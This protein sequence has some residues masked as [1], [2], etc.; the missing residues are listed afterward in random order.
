MGHNITAIVI[1][2]AFARDVASALDLVAVPLV[3]PLTLFHIDHYYTAY[4]PK[5]ALIQTDYF[6]WHRL[7]VGFRVRWRA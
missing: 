4:A 2:D 7:A 5:L 3:E 6:W 1:V